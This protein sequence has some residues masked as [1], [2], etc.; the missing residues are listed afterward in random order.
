MDAP[1]GYIQNM[2]LSR[3]IRDLAAQDARDPVLA[4]GV[5]ASARQLNLG[6]VQTTR[7]CSDEELHRKHRARLRAALLAMADALEAEE[8]EA[9]LEAARED[10][11]QM[12][13]PC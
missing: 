2:P 9:D 5:K 3:A 13:M 1:A 7:V 11:R 8:R 12:V 4:A 10:V 6:I